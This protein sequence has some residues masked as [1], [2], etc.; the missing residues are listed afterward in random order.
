MDCTGNRTFFAFRV[1]CIIMIMIAL[2]LHGTSLRKDAKWDQYVTGA[3]ESEVEHPV[4]FQ[5]KAH[6]SLWKLTVLADY[7]QYEDAQTYTEES[8]KVTEW[9]EEVL[10]W[11]LAGIG[12]GSISFG[13]LIFAS[14]IPFFLRIKKFQI[15]SILC[16]MILCFISAILI[17]RGV[18]QYSGNYQSVI[19]PYVKK[20]EWFYHL[21]DNT[22]AMDFYFAFAASIF[23]LFAGVSLIIH[24]I[25]FIRS[26]ASKKETAVE[27]ICT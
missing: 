14:G 1:S 16:S 26:D 27:S 9:R 23:H 21:S 15:S 13:I 11:E 22:L 19:N 24:L 6:Q 7:N 3:V 8:L 12:M 17:F 20:W 2:I 10:R 18:V 4:V 25:M 5:I